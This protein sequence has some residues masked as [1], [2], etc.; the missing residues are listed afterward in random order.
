MSEL[1]TQV[2]GQEEGWGREER[3]QRASNTTEERR[4]EGGRAGSSLYASKHK[5]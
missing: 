2:H 1:P 4:G 5:A 3:G